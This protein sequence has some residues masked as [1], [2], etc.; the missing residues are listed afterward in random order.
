M[1]TQTL[2]FAKAAGDETRQAIM[3]HLCCVWLSVNEVVEQLGGRVEQ[4]T[5]SHH[6]K[7]LEDAGL[8]FVRQQGR[9]RFYTLNRDAVRACCADLVSCLT[10]GY[11]IVPVG[12]IP[13]PP[14]APTCAG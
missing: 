2:L 11:V 4:P 10:P 9:Q 5:V 7:K 13:H 14:D 6:L 1:E 12:D 8:V 3:N